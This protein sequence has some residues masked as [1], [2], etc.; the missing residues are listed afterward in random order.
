M[1]CLLLQSVPRS[2]CF[3]SSEK[4]KLLKKMKCWE[5]G[6]WLVGREVSKTRSAAWALEWV[7]MQGIVSSCG[8]GS[9]GLLDKR[10]PWIRLWVREE[11]HVG[12]LSSY[13]WD[14]WGWR[15][16]CL[17]SSSKCF[18]QI[19][20]GLCRSLSRISLICNGWPY[21]S[22]Q[23]MEPN[24]FWTRGEIYP[25]SPKYQI[26]CG[27]IFLW[28]MEMVMIRIEFCLSRFGLRACWLWLSPQWQTV[29]EGLV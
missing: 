15:K 17:F 8:G 25:G 2:E 29:L 13:I 14:W 4:G 6:C 16:R 3:S 24:S 1:S 10:P 11:V 5:R 19:K 20:G 18:L 28:T 22:H 23:V 27:C 26:K 12:D 21:C 9:G 7:E